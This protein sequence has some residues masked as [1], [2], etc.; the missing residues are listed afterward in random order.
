MSPNA[1][2]E[3]NSDTFP[4]KGRDGSRLERISASDPAMHR[5]SETKNP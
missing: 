3:D 1:M 5:V 4:A 2:P